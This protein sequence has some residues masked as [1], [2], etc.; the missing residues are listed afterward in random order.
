MKPKFLRFADGKNFNVN[1]V[2]MF[3]ERQESI[4]IYLTP[5]T[6]FR[7]LNGA[8][9]RSNFLKAIEIVDIE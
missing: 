5:N 8:L 1:T 7:T 4:D 3:V 2:V 9:E 6:I